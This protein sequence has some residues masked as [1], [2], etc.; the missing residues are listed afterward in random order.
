MTTTDNSRADALTR[1]PLLVDADC[2]Y[3]PYGMNGETVCKFCGFAKDAARPVEQPRTHTTQ[4]GESVMGIALR[5]CGNEM[6]WRH[7]LA[8]NPEFARMLPHE[9]F[10]VGTVLTLPPPAAASPVEQHEAAPMRELPMMRKAFRVTEVSGDPDP[11]K[12]SFAMRFSFPS[13]DALHCADDEWN[14]FIAATQPEPPA[15]DEQHE[16]APADMT[17]AKPD[18]MTKA[19]KQLADWLLTEPNEGNPLCF[20]GPP[21][22]FALGLSRVKMRSVAGDEWTLIAGL[23]EGWMTAEERASNF[24]RI[25]QQEREEVAREEAVATYQKIRAQAHKNPIGYIEQA[26]FE[27]LG[28][29]EFGDTA[30]SHVRLW[31]PANPPS[32][33]LMPVFVGPVA[34]PAPSAP[35]EGTGNGADGFTYAT[36]QATKCASCGEHKHTPLRIDWMGGYVCL[37]CIDRELES[38]APRTEIAGAV[39]AAVIDALRFYAHGH[40]FSIDDDHQQF[41]TVSGE[42]QNWLMS[43]RDDDCTM[44]ED[45]S[46]A[47]AALCGGVLGFEEPTKPVEGEVLVAAPPS[48]DAAA[49]PADEHLDAPLSLIPHLVAQDEQAV[50]TALLNMSDA[51]C[52]WRIEAGKYREISSHDQSV[53]SDG[54]EAGMAA[55]LSARAAAS[56]PAALAGQEAVAWIR[57]HPDTGE[58]SGDWLWNDA[59]EQCRKDSGV[60]FPLGYLTAPPAQ[61]GAQQP[62][63][64][65]EVTDSRQ[66]RRHWNPIYNTDP[67]QRA[68]EELPDGYEIEI[69]LERGAG[70][71]DVCGPDGGRLDSDFDEDTFDWKIHAAIDAAIDAARAGDEK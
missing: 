41:D 64:R 49:A 58:L 26:E 31:H 11:A 7:I 71:V 28:D 60:W 63:P 36:K 43:E 65:A 3:G 5:Q 19:V 1:C 39:P 50:N 20:A 52:A 48:A 51:I 54:Y 33:A 70:T 6:E 27:K 55:M 34:Q 23:R 22:P 42:P 8:C 30:E 35:L 18:Q 67:V 25:A 12:Q 66:V 2:L 4:P 29:P 40:H 21:E 61:V 47:K 45:G 57:K 68:C 17:P 13:I 59:I 10:P 24:W 44:I 62:K 69:M 46:I 53:F 38:R 32:R 16:A 9:Y 37:T 14:K 56:Q 15:A